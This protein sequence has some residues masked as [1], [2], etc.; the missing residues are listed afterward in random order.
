VEAARVLASLWDDSREDARDNVEAEITAAESVALLE[1]P[2][3]MLEQQE[4][5]DTKSHPEQV[6]Y[7]CTVCR[8]LKRV[9]C[10]HRTL[11]R[12]P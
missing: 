3:V 9:C 4:A 6:T 12:S 2:M 8:E 5:E 7:R 10:V 1:E 11:R